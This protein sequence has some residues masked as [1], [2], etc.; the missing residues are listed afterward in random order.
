MTPAMIPTLS[1]RSRWQLAKT[2]RHSVQTRANT[3]NTKVTLIVALLWEWIGLSYGKGA[4]DHSSIVLSVLTV[5]SV[6]LEQNSSRAA[7][8]HARQVR[9]APSAELHWVFCHG[10]AIVSA[11]CV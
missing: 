4:D 6:V 7:S 3:V 8:R 11:G 2:Q 9:N 5:W 1:A 10:K